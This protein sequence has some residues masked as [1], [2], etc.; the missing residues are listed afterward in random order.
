V[1]NRGVEEWVCRGLGL[2]GV[3]VENGGVEEGGSREREREGVKR[4]AVEGDGGTGV[5]VMDMVGEGGDWDLV[6]LIVGLNM[7]VV[8]KMKH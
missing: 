6:N 5:V 8:M 4:R 1:V 7:G 3:R 2:D